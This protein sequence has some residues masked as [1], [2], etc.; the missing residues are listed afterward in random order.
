MNVM[1]LIFIFMWKPL[2]AFIQFHCLN[3]KN[4]YPCFFFLRFQLF[5][6]NY[7][8]KLIKTLQFQKTNIANRF[9]R[10]KQ[11]ENLY[12]IFLSDIY[13]VSVLSLGNKILRF[14]RKSRFYSKRL[15]KTFRHDFFCV[16]CRE[17]FYIVNNNFQCIFYSV[18]FFFIFFFF[19][20]CKF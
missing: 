17:R 20:Q 8:N 16:L 15:H 12:T 9:Y 11:V 3:E 1:Q 10:K 18:L 14:I 13:F 4:I 7:L 19:I 2:S 6:R 5:M